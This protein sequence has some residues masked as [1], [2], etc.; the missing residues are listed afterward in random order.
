M[1]SEDRV[2]TKFAVE[3]PS[4]AQIEHARRGKLAQGQSLFA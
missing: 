4:G 2:E 1:L 3:L